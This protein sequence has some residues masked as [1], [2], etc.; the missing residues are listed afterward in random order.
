M[1]MERTMI[2]FAKV[3]LNRNE[4]WMLDDAG[5]S[6]KT[7]LRAFAELQQEYQDEVNRNKTYADR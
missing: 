5:Y 6:T 2:E 7:K 4:P 3:Y 1:N